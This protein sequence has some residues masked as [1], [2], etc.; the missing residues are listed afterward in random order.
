ME[1]LGEI[2]MRKKKKKMTPDCTG[3]GKIIVESHCWP[4]EIKK[5]RRGRKQ[6]PKVFP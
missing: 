2:T 3:G 4:V 6:E 5:R 1:N